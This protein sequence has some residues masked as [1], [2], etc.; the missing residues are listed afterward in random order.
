MRDRL[1]IG[2]SSRGSTLRVVTIGDLDFQGSPQLANYVDTVAST[3]DS[4][5]ELD[6]R[7]IRAIDP[8]GVSLLIRLR[9]RFRRRLRII[10]SE[11][12]ARTVHFVARGARNR[13]NAATADGA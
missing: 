8:H 6:L 3:F 4:P 13:R 5:I 11:P 1:R 2:L 12:V 10:P 9:R 7:G